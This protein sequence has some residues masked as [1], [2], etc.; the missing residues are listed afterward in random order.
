M[1]V[2]IFISFLLIIPLFFYASSPSKFL[3]IV[4]DL[5]ISCRSLPYSAS[6]RTTLVYKFDDI[7]THYSFCACSSPSIRYSSCWY[8]CCMTLKELTSSSITLRVY[9]TVL[10]FWSLACW[11]R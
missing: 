10:L 1:V 11:A 9:S 7:L 6:N 3:I 8:S 4:Y 5:F 2:D